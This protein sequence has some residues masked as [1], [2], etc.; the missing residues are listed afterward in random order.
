MDRYIHTYIHEQIDGCVHRH[1]DTCIFVY[2]YINTYVHICS[3]FHD[4]KPSASILIEIDTYT[5]WIDI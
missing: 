5:E 1:I 3:V 2:A 4:V